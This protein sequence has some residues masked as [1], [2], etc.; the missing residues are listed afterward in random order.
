MRERGEE[1]LYPLTD[2]N[3][4]IIAIIDSTGEVKE[5]YRYDAFGK[6]TYL[7]PDFSVKTTSQYDWDFLFTSRRLDKEPGLMYYRN[8]YYH[9]VIG[10]FTTVDPLGYNAGDV[11]LYRYV[12]NQPEILADPIGLD[13]TY[14]L[15]FFPEYGPI[16]MQQNLCQQGVHSLG[17]GHGDIQLPSLPSMPPPATTMNVIIT[18]GGAVLEVNGIISS[19]VSMIGG[20]LLGSIFTDETLNVG[21]EITTEQIIEAI[22]QQQTNPPPSTVSP[23][24]TEEPN[25]EEPDWIWTDDGYCN[26]GQYIPNPNK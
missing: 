25:I 5:R 6:V 26:G 7:N 4:N 13:I 14:S 24:V 19:P 18:V 16:A 8:R 22:I 11:N 10:R 23:P 3:N 12:N 9:P 2:P 15:P 20:T 1:C 17:C 21:A